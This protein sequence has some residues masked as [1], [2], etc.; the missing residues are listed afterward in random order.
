MKKTGVR[1]LVLLVVIG[2]YKNI[3]IQAAAKPYISQKTVSLA[4]GQSIT[5]TVKNNKKG[6]TWSSSNKKIATV[7]KTGKVKGIKKGTTT[8]IAK[9]GSKSYKCSVTVSNQD[10]EVLIVYFS[11]TGTTQSAA[12]KIQKITGG[13][14]VRIQPRNPYT[15]DYD[16]LLDIAQSEQTQDE[17]PALSTT[18]KNWS[19]YDTVIIGYPIWWGEEPMVIRSFLEKQD[20]TGKRLLPFCTSGGSGIEGSMSGI[21]KSADGATIIEGRDLSDAST[22]TIRNWLKNRKVN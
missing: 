13:T 1:I 21:K 3:P 9:I 12:K 15:S 16:R 6:V 19:Q 17:R 22:S 10:T 7:S 5:L 2:I 14:L 4:K 20:W 11:T 8:V 18:I